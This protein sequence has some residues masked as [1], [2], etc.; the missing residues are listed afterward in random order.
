MQGRLSPDPNGF[1]QFFPERWEKEF[2]LARELG[3]D[4]VEWLWD[5]RNWEQNPI[6]SDEGMAMIKKTIQE[7]GVPIDSL[8][9]DYFM[10]HSFFG[11]DASKSI[12]LLKQLTLNVK[13]LGIKSIVIPF[14]EE[15]AIK[16]EVVKKEIIDNLKKVIPL[17]EESN[18]KINFETEMNTNELA[19]FTNSFN[20]FSVGACYDLGNA[21][22][23]GF[24]ASKDIKQLGKLVGEVH[25]KDRKIGTTKSVLFGQGDVD[26][27]ACFTALKE[28]NFNGP[29]VLQAWRGDDYLNDA[30][31]QLAFVKEVVNSI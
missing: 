31:N 20:S 10:K 25:L 7:I 17:A 19:D 23:Y 6:L 26:F 3:F 12:E 22:S 4:A 14:L 28:V 16:D 18:V 29:I 15:L 8:C 27:K 24:N 5:W 1:F 2:R 13:V 9:T 30:K 11:S 21:V